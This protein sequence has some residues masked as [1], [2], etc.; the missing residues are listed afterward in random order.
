[1]RHCQ[2][3]HVAVRG[4]QAAIIEIH[5]L[6]AEFVPRHDQRNCIARVRDPPVPRTG[7]Y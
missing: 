1:M 6:E 3:A 2:P 4:A 5:V 7:A